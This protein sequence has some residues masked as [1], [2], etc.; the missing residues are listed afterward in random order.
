MTAPSS[1]FPS[2]LPEANSTAFKDIT[3]PESG[4]SHPNAVWS[5]AEAG[6]QAQQW[7]PFLTAA[8]TD[9]TTFAGVDNGT[10]TMQSA[11]QNFQKQLVAYAKSEGFNVTQ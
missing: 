11:M 10:E 5:Q 7:P 2:Y 6:I 9:S 8:L 4:N 1:L 3:A